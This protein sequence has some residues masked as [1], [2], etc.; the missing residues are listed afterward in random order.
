MNNQTQTQTNRYKFLNDDNQHI[1]T[2]DG[3]PLFGTSTVL[4]VLSKPLTWWASGLAVGH[5]GW[6]PIND[7]KTRRK[8]PKEDR[9]KA[10]EERFG[11]IKNMT[12][13]EFLCC[14]DEAYAAHSRKLKTSADTGIDMHA[15]LEKY[16]K[17]CMDF[18]DGAPREGLEHEHYAVQLFAKWSMD[19]VKEFEVSEGYCYSERLW[20]GGIVDLIF[21]DKDDRVCVFDFKSAKAAYDAHFLQDAGYH[22]AIAENGVYDC[23]GNLVLRYGESIDSA[24]YGVFPFGMENPEPQFRRD[25]DRLRKGFEASVVL[26]DLLNSSN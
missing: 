13:E 17:S 26:H 16:V 9:L 24:Y 14:L 20:T 10:V 11:I 4:N 23:D 5:L 21:L 25:T 6:T 22:I 19:N 15:E 2:L 8:F 1:H 18:N 12:N 3:K 7:P